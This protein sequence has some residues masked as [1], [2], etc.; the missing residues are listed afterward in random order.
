MEK[1]FILR[2]DMIRSKGRFGRPAQA[3]IVPQNRSQMNAFVMRRL[4]LRGACGQSTGEAYK[5]CAEY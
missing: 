2:S 4:V 3:Q 5:R 1:T